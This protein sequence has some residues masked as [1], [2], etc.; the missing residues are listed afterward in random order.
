MSRCAVSFLLIA[1][2][3]WG[4]APQPSLAHGS[5]SDSGHGA[6]YLIIT[7]DQFYNAIQPLADWKHKKGMQ[8]RVTKLSEI[9][10]SDPALIEDY[11]QNAYYS[12]AVRPEYVLLVGDPNY[13]P[14][15]SM[16]FWVWSDNPYGNVDTDLYNEIIPG[17]IPGNDETTIA[18]V[19]NKI[20]GYERNPY[21]GDPLWFRKGT[22]IVR[23]DGDAD[24]SIYWYDAHTAA[25]LMI[26]N[27]YIA[28]DSFSYFR[29]DNAADVV[30]AI[31]SGRSLVMFRGQ[32]T[33]MWWSPFNV[34]PSST[35]NG[36]KLPVIFSG[37]CEQIDHSRG[38]CGE[39]WV[40][41]GTPTQPRGA[42]G[43]CGPS[44]TLMGGANLRSAEVQGFLRGLFLTDSLYTLGRACEAARRF[45]Y[46]RWN[47]RS[48]YNGF[49]CIGDPE[50]NIWTATPSPLQVSY[51]G[52]IPVG[53][54]QFTVTVHHNG[55]PVPKALVCTMADEEEKVYEY[56]YTNALGQVTLSLAPSQPD[57]L[58]VTVTARNFLPHEG[59][60][61]ITQ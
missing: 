6:R 24:D 54:N 3:G 10:G 34:D 47:S 61:L 46:R 7:P 44:T 52:S 15:P 53:P 36:Y 40:K 11:I 42:I 27:G 45:V 14:M 18:T 57:T 60:S 31:N 35:S 30:A 28:V 39:R 1:L 29:G 16:G 12:W 56:G 51:P 25:R 20:L 5:R 50:L 59:Y 4:L 38:S 23:E 22:T 43:F 32:S 21:L 19:V 48:E 9:G 17:R 37:T 13:I 58:R 49:V 26:R 2:L 41:T 8:T 55:S 33:C